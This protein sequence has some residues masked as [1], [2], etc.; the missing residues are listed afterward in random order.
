MPDIYLGAKKGWGPAT[1]TVPTSPTFYSG[2]NQWQTGGAPVPTPAPSYNPPQQT[3]VQRPPFNSGNY[4]QPPAAPP[5]TPPNTPSGPQ[6]PTQ[7]IP[8]PG[9]GGG[10]NGPGTGIP[11]QQ[12]E[13]Y[14]RMVPGMAPIPI[15]T[16]N[17]VQ[18]PVQGPNGGG[19]SPAPAN[20]NMGNPAPQ[21][22]W[23]LPAPDASGSAKLAARTGFDANGT[24]WHN[25]PEGVQLYSLNQFQGSPMMDAAYPAPSVAPQQSQQQMQTQQAGGQR[26]LPSYALDPNYNPTSAEVEAFG[27][28]AAWKAAYEAQSGNKVGTP[29]PYEPG[30]MEVVRD[31]NGNV[32]AAGAQ[33]GYKVGDSFEQANRYVGSGQL[34]TQYQQAIQNS[35]NM[36]E[37]DRADLNRLNTE[38]QQA[39][40]MGKI[41]E[42][43]ALSFQQNAFSTTSQKYQVASSYANPRALGNNAA[44]SQVGHITPPTVGDAG[45]TDFIGPAGRTYEQVLGTEYL[46]EEERAWFLGQQ[47]AK[48]AMPAITPPTFDNLQAPEPSQIPAGTGKWSDWGEGVTYNGQ[49]FGALGRAPYQGQ[50]QFA[51]EVEQHRALVEKY[52]RPEDVNKA[53]YVISKESGGRSI[54]QMNS[55][56]EQVGPAWGLFQIEDN[57][58]HAGRPSREQLLD[59]EFNVRMAAKMVY[60]G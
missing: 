57:T 59:P 1:T 45:L 7:P 19:G 54:G 16:M 20:P 18:G 17:G 48:R 22:G 33:S 28:R 52:F 26:Q 21:G 3:T 56:G 49:A 9:T 47:S 4:Q 41:D 10:W 55:A 8:T 34:N 31:M 46:S 11:S 58:Q 2:P 12:L 43:T 30:P 32:I 38:L 53:L 27:G 51:P 60:G 14:G 25:A 6:T 13:Y 23:A 29:G 42:A 50:T 40:R 24:Y 39:Y 37:R 36:S 44:T 35:P 5:V 15:T